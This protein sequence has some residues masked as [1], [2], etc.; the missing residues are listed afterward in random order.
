MT[1]IPSTFLFLTALGAFSAVVLVFA[2]R[3]LSVPSDPKVDAVVAAL[4]GANC[5]ACGYSG[6]A[7]AA[8]AVVRG[9]ANVNVCL[10][11]SA[12]V[13]SAIAAIMG[14]EAAVV[15]KKRAFLQCSRPLCEPLARF[16]YEGIPDCRAAVMLHGGPKTCAGGCIGMGTCLT[17]CPVD[18]ITM[19]NGLPQIDPKRCTG[20]GKCVEI[21]PKN[22]LTLIEDSATAEGKKRCAEYCV[23]DTLKFEVDQ[24]KCISCGICFKNCPADAIRWE[25]GTAAF[26]DREKCIGCYT[27]MRL[28]PVKVIG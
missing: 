15:K 19:K 28:C 25:K 18:A 6:C 27:C 8:E 10:I 14:I 13:S 7:A 1:A 26:L 4:P 22:I 23:S 16:I 12:E 21:C 9:E 5:G 3:F 24:E 20:C 2:A 11:G 17:V